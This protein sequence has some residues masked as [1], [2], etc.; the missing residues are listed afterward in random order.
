MKRRPDGR[1]QK[2]I[3]LPNGKT[4]LL[5]SSAAT[6][7]LANKEFNDIIMNLTQQSE[8]K[9]LFKK[10]AEKW[11]GEYQEKIS[12]I[13]YRK[14]PKASYDRI[15][16]HFEKYYIE[17]ITPNEI[18]TYINSLIKEKYSQ[19]SIS[20]TKSILNMIFNYA[21]LEGYIKSNP[22]SIIKLPSNLP[23]KQRE[24]PSD[25]ELK[26]VN[27][28]YEGFDFLPFFLLNTGLRLSEALALEYSDIDFK[29]KTITVA[30][31]LLFDGNRPVLEHSTKTASSK[32]TVILLDRVAE[33][34]SPSAT[35]HLFC[36]EDGSYLTKCQ[37]SKRWEKWQ[38]T[39]GTTV[40]A[41]QLRHGFATMLFEAGVDLKDAQD[42][43][44]HSDIK[45]TH[46]I[47]THIRDKRKKETAEKLNNFT[48]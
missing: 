22:V 27:E 2:R 43:M 21:I 38:K 44:G 41:H 40:T 5:Y 6:E 1:W 20:T 31:H 32:R 7:R 33:K 39:Y 46:E 48:F 29:A 10:I 15:L 35:G 30:K 16:S 26:I 25:E 36:N 42:L 19:K 4:K 14:G 45:I 8:R 37:L 24:M 18:N 47:Y 12:A 28:H 9:T 34:L 11:N 17:S 23:K 3:T 13:N